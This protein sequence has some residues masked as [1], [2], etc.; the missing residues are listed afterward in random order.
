MSENENSI[1][2]FCPLTRCSCRKDCALLIT[3]FD[4]SSDDSES[5]GD[6]VCGLLLLG[7]ELSTLIDCS[8]RFTIK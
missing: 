2:L 6:S 8:Y 3:K 1:D 5:D 7:Q 4:S